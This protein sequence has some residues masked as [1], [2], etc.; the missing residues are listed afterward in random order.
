M[1]DVHGGPTG[2]ATVRWDGWLRFFTSRGWAVLRPNPRG[3]T[4]YGRGYV[5]AAARRWG[6]DDVED[7]AAGIRAAGEQGWCDPERVAIAGGSSGGLTALLVCARHGDL[8]RAAVSA[9]GVTDLFDLARTTHRFESRYLDEIVGP[10]PDAEA[11]YR[12]RSPITHAAAIRVPLLVLQGDADEVVPK[13]QADALVAAVRAAGG[14]VDSRV[15]EG[16]GHGWTREETI[17]DELERT[18][19]FLERWVTA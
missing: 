16:E 13:A 8:V 1:V 19:A 15:Y 14:T 9:Y 11:A 2:Q 6:V 17:A 18:I 10:L 12:D 3:S 7:V 4:G 5:Q